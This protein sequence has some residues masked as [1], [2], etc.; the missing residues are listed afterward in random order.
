MRTCVRFVMPWVPRYSRDDAA[1]AIAV[2]ETWADAL[3]RLGVWPRGKN[4]TTLRKWAERWGIPTDHLPA[5]QPRR[6]RPRFTE[7]EAREAVASSRSWSEALRKLGYCP[8]GANP[9]TLKRWVAEWGISTEHFDPR[10]A[11][12]MAL[13]RANRPTPLKD[14]LVENS[15]YSRNKLKDRLYR[16]GLKERVC[17]LCGQTEEWHGRRM[18]LIL[19]HINGTRDDNRLENLRIVCP[20]CAATLDTHCGRR[21]RLLPATRQCARCEQ[22]FIPKYQ[23][24]RYCSRECGSRWDRTGLPLRAGRKTARPPEDQ[25]VAEVEEKGYSAVGRKYGVSDNAV[26]KWVRQYARERAIAEGRDP[27]VVEIPTRTWPNRRR[28]EEAA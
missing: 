1:S 22:E 20:N 12:R 7:A 6:A 16:E 25:L 4:Y 14:I 21:T 3:I 24:H 18:A 26:R 8:T 13:L 9:K 23:D 19:D 10:A 5:Y 2:S 11:V 28:D 27:T 15:T 17:E